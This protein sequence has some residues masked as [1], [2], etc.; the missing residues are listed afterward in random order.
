METRAI[1]QWL[2]VLCLFG[3]VQPAKADAGDVIAILLGVVIAIII[4][5]AFIG[6]KSGRV[7]M[8]SAGYEETDDFEED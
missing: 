7:E 2:C 3:L 6:Y 5:C 1:L 8:T 4:A